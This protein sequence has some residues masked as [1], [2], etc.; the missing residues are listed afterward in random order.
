V[1]AEDDD[2]IDAHGYEDLTPLPSL[3][4]IISP[5]QADLDVALA[6]CNQLRSANA[7]LQARNDEQTSV[8]R[9]LHADRRA[10]ALRV[11]QLEKKESR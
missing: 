8:I 6:T 3:G 7:A 5:L 1:A 2:G 10:L 4:P 9:K 11:Q